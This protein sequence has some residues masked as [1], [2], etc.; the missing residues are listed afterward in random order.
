MKRWLILLLLSVTLT[1]CVISDP[2]DAKK[3]NANNISAY[4]SGVFEQD[5]QDN[6]KYF[7]NTWYVARFLKASD[8]EKVSSKYDNIR[9]T[10]RQNGGNYTFDSLTITFSM[11]DP[12]TVG[13]TWGIKQSYRRELIVT[14]R[15]ETEWK[16]ESETD[17]VVI[18][19]TLISAD[20]TGMKM[21]VQVRGKWTEESDYSADFES[22]SIDAE[23]VNKNPIAIDKIYYSGKM[24]FDF[25]EGD[26]EIMK[27]EMI[28][29]TDFLS[30]FSAWNIF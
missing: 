5:V 3:L 9:T 26:D 21:N 16:I 12:F 17:D 7:Y 28:L 2:Y 6:I 13:S 25:F 24:M 30:V 23:I 8:E 10:L 15:S 11:N 29:S 19:L 1:S 20:D 22:E 18:L 4:C 27:C 14:M